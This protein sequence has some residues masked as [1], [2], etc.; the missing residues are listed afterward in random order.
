[1]YEAIIQIYKYITE[2]HLVREE[3]VPEQG[4]ASRSRA[5]NVEELENKFFFK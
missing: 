1:M 4:D 5:P 3:A 2:H